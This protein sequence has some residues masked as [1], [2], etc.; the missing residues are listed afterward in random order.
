MHLFESKKGDRWVCQHCAREEAEMIDTEGWEYIF[1]R[2]EQD[3]ICSICQ[4]PEYT[5]ED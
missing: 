5:P 1:D 2:Y 4:K 3:I